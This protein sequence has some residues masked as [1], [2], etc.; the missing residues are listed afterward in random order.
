MI[1]MINKLTKTEMWVHESRAEAYKAAGHKPAAP[2][3]VAEAAEIIS[4]DKDEIQED[5]KDES[6]LDQDDLP[7][8]KPAKKKG[9]K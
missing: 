8:Q 3:T 9:K 6:V 4:D 2:A 7:E 1:R 5:D